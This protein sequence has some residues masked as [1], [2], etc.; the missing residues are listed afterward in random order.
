MIAASMDD[1][2]N[3]E[4]ELGQRIAKLEQ[5][6]DKLEGYLH[7]HHRGAPSR[8]VYKAVD[9]LNELSLDSA[10][11]DAQRQRCRALARVLGAHYPFGLEDE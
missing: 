6:F 3:A 10:L 8:V 9:L 4:L 2:Q 7:S 5:R 11:T 1:L